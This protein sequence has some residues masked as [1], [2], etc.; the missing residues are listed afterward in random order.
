[1]LVRIV[2]EKARWARGEVIRWMEEGE[3]RCEA[4]CP[5]YARCDG[6]SLQHLAYEE[7]IRWKGRFVGDALRRVG[8]LQT[9]DP[10]VSPSPQELRY[11]NKVT[12]TLRRLP[13]GRIVAGFRE[14]GHQGRVLDV[15]SSCLLPEEPL[16]D[17]WT[18]LQ[19]NWGAGAALLPGGRELRITLRSGLEGVSLTF[20]GGRGRGNPE[21]LLARLPGFASIWE[22]RKREGPRHLAGEKSLQVQWGEELLDLPG[23]GFIQVNRGAGEALHEHV[24]EEA[25]GVEDKTIIDAYCGAGV[26]GRAMA[27]RG[28]RVVGIDLDPAAVGVRSS[29][30]A[31]GFRT[32]LG[33]VE[34]QLTDFLPADLVILN[35]PRTGLAESIPTALGGSGAGH[36]DLCEL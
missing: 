19:A 1:M 14:L 13:G 12:F 2:K 28:D 23:A 10:L 7:Q 31:E 32:V 33:R 3:G 34:E 21:G 18:S 36:G 35:P 9:D 29:L 6:C 11:R 8:G 16:M 26:L 27:R 25:G 24:L 15:G 5:M 30:E 20:R 4:P 17:A 22:E